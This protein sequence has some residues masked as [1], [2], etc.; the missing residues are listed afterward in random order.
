M[1]LDLR[2]E[3]GKRIAQ[4]EIQFPGMETVNRN[5]QDNHR[6]AKNTTDVD[7]CTTIARPFRLNDAFRAGQFSQTRRHKSS[8]L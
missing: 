1:R 5:L 3:I 7:I 2:I 8:N 6:P 4:L